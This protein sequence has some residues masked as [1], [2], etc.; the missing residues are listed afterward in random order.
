M[1]EVDG[2]DEGEGFDFFD[3]GIDGGGEKFSAFAVASLF[4]R[5]QLEEVQQ[6]IIDFRKMFADD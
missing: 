6:L 3:F 1:L 2:F 4:H 5:F